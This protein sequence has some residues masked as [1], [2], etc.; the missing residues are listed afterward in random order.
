[1]IKGRNIDGDVMSV[2]SN[3]IFDLSGAAES[4]IMLFNAKSDIRINSISLFYNEATSADA[5]VAI[6]FG[7][8]A[9]ATTFGTTTSEL[10][11]AIGYVKTIDGAELTTDIITKGT[12]FTVANAG[13]KVG[14][15]T[16]IASVNYT[17]L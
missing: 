6:N 4:E 8:V 13:G 14:T 3:T 16:F 17:V 2:K 7:N 1:M 11:K 5:G 10:S 12:I 9:S 15:G